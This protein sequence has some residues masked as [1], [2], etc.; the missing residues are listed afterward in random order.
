M[1]PTFVVSSI[2]IERS[3]IRHQCYLFSDMISTYVASVS[4][5][6]EEGHPIRRQNFATFIR[7]RKFVARDHIFSGVSF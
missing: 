1:Q 5:G 2:D 6:F 7:P 3:D 4:E